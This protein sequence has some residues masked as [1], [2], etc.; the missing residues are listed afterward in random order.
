MN[1]TCLTNIGLS[2]LSLNTGC[3]RIVMTFSKITCSP[4]RKRKSRVLMYGDGTLQSTL[5]IGGWLFSLAITV[6]KL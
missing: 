2:C 1:S 3:S 4:D 6:D 5:L